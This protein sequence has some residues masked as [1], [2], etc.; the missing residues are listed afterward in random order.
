MGD[1]EPLGLLLFAV[2]ER[3]VIALGTGVDYL[4]RM[5]EAPLGR[6]GGE[7]DRGSV[8]K[9]CCYGSILAGDRLVIAEGP[10][11]AARRQG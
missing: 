2:C 11:Q 3:S 10:S 1:S 8:H 6:F 7:R 5:K 4:A 9:G